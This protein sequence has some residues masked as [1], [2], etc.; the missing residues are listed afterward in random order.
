MFPYDSSKEKEDGV[1]DQKR[2]EA[3]I[4]NETKNVSFFFCRV[5][6]IIILFVHITHIYGLSAK[7]GNVFGVK[8]LNNAFLEN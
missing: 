5:Q 2:P 4:K 3:T 7:I 8:E 6:C 1:S